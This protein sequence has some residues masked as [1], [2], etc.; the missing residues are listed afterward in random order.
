MFCPKCSQK[1]ISD[2]IK[3]CS[4]C[5]F[6]LLDVAEALNNDGRV[7][8]NVIPVSRE[9]KLT[10]VKGVSI[11]SLGGIFLLISLI[12]GTPEPGYFVQFNLFAGIL[13][14]LFGILLIGY[15]FWIKPKFS[16]KNREPNTPETAQLKNSQINELPE[17][18]FSDLA[19]Y[20][21]PT[22]GFTTRELG[23]P[24]SIT[25]QTTRNLKKEL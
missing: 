8:R 23:D 20:S 11:M 19:D 24:V 22:P 12:L 16:E 18:D 21:P 4:K 2:E 7:E 6:S 14:F 3:F 10:T 9:L 15:N 25:E 1:Q 5:G 17:A 13:M